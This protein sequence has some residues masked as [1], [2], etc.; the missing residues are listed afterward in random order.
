MAYAS[1]PT[2]TAIA[3]LM[4]QA[5]VVLKVA[6][7]ELTYAQFKGW[8]KDEKEYDATGLRH[9]AASLSSAG[10]FVQ[11]RNAYFPG[12]ETEA[13]LERTELRGT[14]REQRLAT[15]VVADQALFLRAFEKRLTEVL[16]KNGKVRPFGYSVKKSKE[17]EERVV[18]LL[19]SD[20][21]FG[22][23][24]DPREVP[25]KYGYVEESRRLASV[26]KRT[27]EFKVDYRPVTKLKVWFGGDIIKGLI[28]DMQTGV[29]LAEQ[30]A[31]AMYLL[32]QALTVLAGSYPSVEVFCSSGNHDRNVAR[33]HDRAT[34][35]KFD[36][37]AT[38]VYNAVK[39]SM[40]HLPNVTMH[41]PRT[42]WCE[43]TNFG[44]KLYLTHGDTNLNPGN[45][46]NSIDVRKLE[47][48]MNRIN[49]GEAENGR[50][51]FE[52]FAVGHVHVGSQS[53]LGPG[54]L[55][56]N[57][58]LIP[59]DPYATSLNYIAVRSGQ[60][61]FESTPHRLVGDYRFLEVDKVT[62]RD[63]SLDKVIAPW[64]GNF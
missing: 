30:Q 56:T 3:E 45:P 36:S 6:T 26:V 62:D 10:G 28:H 42:A 48:Q 2:T 49:A 15:A 47:N 5:A 50:K 17:R 33:H 41:I 59:P 29:S 37:Y 21:H 12:V 58:A 51:P 52:A 11:V 38:T 43:V 54:I 23:W 46:G 4:P 32:D 34:A 24:L 20:L 57:G 44:R 18:N 13:L 1:T 19:L 27:I 7:S 35:G 60:T 25:Y 64:S 55:L 31:D 22:S 8:L 40:R 9:L 53:Q 63:A 16:A 61:L 39:L 14:A